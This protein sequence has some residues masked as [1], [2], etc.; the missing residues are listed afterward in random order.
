MFVGVGVG[1]YAAGIFHLVTHA[2]FKALLFLGRGQRHP[3]AGRRAGPAQDGRARAAMMTTTITFLIGAL[4]LSRACRR[5]PASSRRTRSSPP[6]STRATALLWLLLL[7]GAFMTAFYTFRLVVPRLLRRPAHVARRSRT[8]STSRPR[9]MT[10]PAD[11]RSPSLT[12]VAGLAFGIPSSHGTA[13]RALPRP[14]AAAS[15]RPSTARASRSR[16]CSLSAV[17]A[18]AGVALAWYVYGRAPVRAALDRGAAQRAPP[19]AAEQV[20][21]GRDL[22]RP[23]RAPD[24]PPLRVWCARVFD[25]GVIDG[26][27]NGVARASCWRWARGLRRVQTGFVMNYALGMLLGAVAVV[28]YLLR[29]PVARMTSCSARHLP[30]RGRRRCSCCCCRAA[31]RSTCQGGDASRRRSSPSSSRCPLYFRFDPTHRGLPVRGA[32]GVDAVA[33]RLATTWAWTASACCWCC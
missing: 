10:V 6:P 7:A 8:T 19:A 12:V 2:F 11:R 29:A 17:V 33:R 1:A 31:A 25:L 27:V 9:C 15:P 16:S 14:G 18:V 4:R 22:R 24:L 3:R 20:L 13:V 28:A 30:A 23:V 26:L 32:A 5:W 21:R